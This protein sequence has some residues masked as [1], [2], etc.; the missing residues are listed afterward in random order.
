M[1]LA[2]FLGV[3]AAVYLLVWLVLVYFVAR[4]LGIWGR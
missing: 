4:L 3:S 2:L 1:R